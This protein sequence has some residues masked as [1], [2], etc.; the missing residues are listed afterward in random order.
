MSKTILWILVTA[1]MAAM[2]VIAPNTLWLARSSAVVRN[3]GNDAI[4]LRIVIIDH[5]DRIVEAGELPPG[6]SRF[7]WVDPVGEATLAVEV[8]DGDDWQRHCGEYVEA[9]MYRV[10][11]LVRAP[12]SVT[13]RTELPLLNRL[14]LADYLS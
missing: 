5:T 12:D 11:V 7:L 2:L 10:E 4:T 14:F 3:I 6:A 9:G 8:L 1:I 13:C